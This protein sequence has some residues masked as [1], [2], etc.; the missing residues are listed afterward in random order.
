MVSPFLTTNGAV[1]FAWLEAGPTAPVSRPF[2]FLEAFLGGTSHGRMGKKPTFSQLLPSQTLSLWESVAHSAV[3]CGTLAC[4][5]WQ[6]PGPGRMWAS[7]IDLSAQAGQHQFEY[8]Q[9]FSPVFS[10]PAFL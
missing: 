5:T 2:L 4:H 3:A 8:F 9:P 1:A 10:A 7:I 6:P